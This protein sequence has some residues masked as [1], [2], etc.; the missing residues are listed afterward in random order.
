MSKN[1]KNPPDS[2]GAIF[3][4][5][6]YIVRIKMLVDFLILGVILKIYFIKK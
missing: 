4:Q 6:L 3:K 5:I 2:E 1:S